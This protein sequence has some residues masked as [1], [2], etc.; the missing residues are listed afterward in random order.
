MT[1]SDQDLVFCEEGKQH[2]GC[3]ACQWQQSQASNTVQADEEVPLVIRVDGKAV[4]LLD[5]VLI[6]PNSPDNV[7]HVGQIMQLIKRPQKTAKVRI[8]MRKAALKS[9]Y[10]GHVSPSGVSLCNSVGQESLHQEKLLYYTGQWRMI[11]ISEIVRQI[12]VLP[13]SVQE[14]LVLPATPILLQDRLKLTPH[15][16]DDPTVFFVDST[17]N[18]DMASTVGDLQ[19]LQPATV[20]CCEV[21]QM[22]FACHVFLHSF[23]RVWASA[24]GLK[25]IDP[26]A[27]GGG[28]TLGLKMA[29]QL[30]PHADSGCIETSWAVEKS[31][32]ACLTLLCVACD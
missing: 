11:P 26:F 21:C 7:C 18:L 16:M 32:D 29:G 28:M 30:W 24:N 8:L 1:H 12:M 10:K 2:W 9:S 14:Y 4:H 31:P 19:K 20:Q 27:G 3:S 15:I 25:A 6:K 23:F 22:D 13:G 5:F 17:T